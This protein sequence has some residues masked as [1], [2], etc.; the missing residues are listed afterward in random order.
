MKYKNTWHVEHVTLPAMEEY[1]R[2]QKEKGLIPEDWKVQT[3]D[4]HP[5]FP[6]WE[7]KWHGQQGF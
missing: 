3:L 5:F 7:E 1:E 2:E 4:E 6:G